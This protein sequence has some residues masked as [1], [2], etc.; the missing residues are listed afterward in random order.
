MLDSEPETSIYSVGY[1]FK[2]GIDAHVLCT[3]LIVI[4][5]ITIKNH[6]TFFYENNE[7]LLILRNVG[8]IPVY[9]ELKMIKLNKLFPF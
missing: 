6:S 8:L 5:Q 4:V 3:N 2:V 7:K 9:R 1:A